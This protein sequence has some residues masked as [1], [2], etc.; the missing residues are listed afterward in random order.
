MLLNPL[1][2]F[3]GYFAGILYLVGAGAVWG[4]GVRRPVMA[5]LALWWGGLLLAFNFAPLDASFTRPLFYHFARTL[6][7][8][9]VPFVLAVALWLCRGLTGRPLVRTI[10]VVPMAG[11]ALVGIVLTRADY[12]AWA[13]VARQA[14]PI[15]ERLP[16][17]A[18]VVTDPMTASQLGFLLPARRDRIR[19]Y[20][21]GL[22]APG[23]GPIFVLSNPVLLAHTR[24]RGDTPPDVMVRPLAA[25][26]RVAQFDHPRRPSL[27]GTLR[28]LLSGN[29]DGLAGAPAAA[30]WRTR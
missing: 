15:V 10:V 2:G 27:R 14:A 8:L 26:E 7:P 6:H 21:S 30:L 11:L 1:S 17:D 28:R 4:L 3:F 20:A 12:R 5:E 29:P 13:A 9:L 24:H 18:R 25:W 23:D 19:S 16:A 22:T